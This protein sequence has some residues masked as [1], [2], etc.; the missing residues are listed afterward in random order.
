MLWE[1]QAKVFPTCPLWSCSF[2]LQGLRLLPLLCPGL[3]VIL[4]IEEADYNPFLVTSTGA[5]IVIHDQDEYP[6]IEDIGTEIETA[7]ATSIGMHFVSASNSGSLAQEVGQAP[8]A[9]RLCGKWGF[10]TFFDLLK[11]ASPGQVRKK[12]SWSSGTVGR[13]MFPWWSQAPSPGFPQAYPQQSSFLSCCRP[14]PTVSAG[15]TAT[16]RRTELMFL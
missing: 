15:H 13:R 11:A 7:T 9:E 16:A 4:Y 5:K 1:K 8:P 10:H 14:H 3:Q 12:P 6:F 2:Y